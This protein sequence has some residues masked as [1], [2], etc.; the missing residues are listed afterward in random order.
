MKTTEER[1][2]LLKDFLQDSLGE[3]PSWYQ[4]FEK[5]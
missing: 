5:Q 3:T 2:E 4:K 1:M